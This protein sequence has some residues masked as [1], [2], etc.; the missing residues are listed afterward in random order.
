MKFIDLDMEIGPEGEEIDDG[1]GEMGS[2]KTKEGGGR[3]R[4][5]PGQEEEEEEFGE[6]EEKAN[7]KD[8][9]RK[10]EERGG[11]REVTG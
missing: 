6:G 9:Q 8:K 5:C 4:T 11:G 3:G 1:I 7:R 2:G 10:A